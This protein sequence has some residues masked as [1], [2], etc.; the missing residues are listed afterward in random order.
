M[1]Q[2]IMR[3]IDQRPD[4]FGPLC[5][6]PLENRLSKDHGIRDDRMQGPETVASSPERASRKPDTA[7]K[8]TG[9]TGNRANWL[10]T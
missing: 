5:I 9:A 7:S 1:A 4:H 8:C 6:N 10:V 2:Q 3:E